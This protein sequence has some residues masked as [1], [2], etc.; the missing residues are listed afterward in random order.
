[1]EGGK[2]CPNGSKRV[3]SICKK[4]SP[5]NSRKNPSQ[6]SPCKIKRTKTGSGKEIRSSSPKTPKGYVSSG[7]GTDLI[8]GKRDYFYVKWKGDYKETSECVE[9]PAGSGWKK[10]MS[11]KDLS[12]DIGKETN[13]SLWVRKV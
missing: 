6:K 3:G 7:G 8:T 12:E 9:K 13:K 10:F 1:M 2:R 4:N 5:A 11:A